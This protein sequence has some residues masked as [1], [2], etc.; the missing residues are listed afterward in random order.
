MKKRLLVI[1]LAICMVMTMTPAMSFADDEQTTNSTGSPAE[2]L[3]GLDGKIPNEYTKAE[4]TSDDG[5]NPMGLKSGEIRQLVVKN[6][7]YIGIH[8]GEPSGDQGETSY[9]TIYGRDSGSI[10]WNKHEAGTSIGGATD[11]KYSQVVGSFVQAVP[12]NVLGHNKDD[13]VAYVYVTEDQELYAACDY[14]ADGAL[15]QVTLLSDSEPFLDLGNDLDQWWA[16]NMMAITAGDYNGDGK[17]EVAIGYNTTVSG[18]SQGIR[19]KVLSFGGDRTKPATLLCTDYFTATGSG[20]GDGDYSS[21]DLASG[22]FNNDGLDD[23]AAIQYRGRTT[24]K[25]ASRTRLYVFTGT[26]NSSRILSSPGK[27]Y[28]STTAD[29][30]FYGPSIDAGDVNGDGVEDIVVAGYEVTYNDDNKP[31]YDE[32]NVRVV[33]YRV[34]EGSTSI[35]SRAAYTTPMNGFAKGGVYSSADDAW[36]KVALAC[37]ATNGKKAPEQ[38]FLDGYLCAVVGAELSTVYAPQYFGSSDHGVTDPDGESHSIKNAF[39]ET[40]V[41]GVFDGN[42]AGREQVAFSVALKIESRDEYYYESGILGGRRYEDEKDSDGRIASY[43]TCTDY[44]SNYFEEEYVNPDGRVMLDAGDDLEYAMYYTMVP[45]D[46]DDDGLYATYEGMNY[47]YSDPHVDA[48]LQAAPYFGDLIGDG[49]PYCGETAYEVTKSYTME[50]T[51]S[52]NVSFGVTVTS[53]IQAGADVGIANLTISQSLEAGYQMEWTQT[54]TDSL[55]TSYTQ[56]FTADSYDTVLI[57]RTPSLVYTYKLAGSSD[58][59]DTNA[60]YITYSIPQGPIYYQMSIDEYNDFVD[61]YNAK[62]D[63]LNV[64]TLSDAQKRQMVKLIKIDDE[65]LDE[66]EGDP[67]KYRPDW[68]DDDHNAVNLSQS[69]LT[70]GYNSGTATNTWT[71]ESAYSEGVEMEHGFHYGL[72]TEFEGGLLGNGPSLGFGFSLDYKHGTGTCETTANEKSCSGTVT[73]IDPEDM[74]QLGYDETTY[75]AF[76]F[77]WSF[78]KWDI[79][80]SEPICTTVADPDD[81]DEIWWTEERIKDNCNTPVFGYAVTNVTRPAVAPYKLKVQT[82]E[83]SGTDS[84]DLSWLVP[85]NLDTSQILGYHVAIVD[86]DGSYNVIE[87]LLIPANVTEYTLSGLESDT[88][89]TLAIC[90]VTPDPADIHNKT[91]NGLWSNTGTDRTDKKQYTVTLVYN[92]RH[93]TG[94]EVTYLGNIPI[95][96]GSRCL[97]SL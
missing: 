2:E 90:A 92:D 59:D 22:D 33:V 35:Q 78:G 36:S 82:S 23:I 29:Y 43:G 42:E 66:N 69:D 5:D 44:F 24:S 40:A 70:L 54:F 84:M 56:S 95:A 88:E 67:S 28:A 8:D 71:T 80:S 55:T 46:I 7:L 81:E 26:T 38:L 74:E 63:T 9:N 68:A 6:E 53:G 32:E 18:Q 57:Q 50:K 11:V 1:L 51:S 75:R 12:V 85:S 89:Y 21:I 34:R 49:A 77:K 93:V 39:I 16:K 27:S 25:D 4:A 15:D 48:V 83:L 41:A 37:V 45:V 19:I 60:E 97:R 20:T 10:D 31:V 52:D 47:A 79:T 17:D 62:I 73:N 14:Y 65:Y 76:G 94:V 3:L 58:S 96:S 61:I 86:E 72:S 87:D 64:S 13:A 30:D 91:I